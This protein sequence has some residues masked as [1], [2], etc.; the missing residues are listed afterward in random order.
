M[1]MY[2][3]FLDEGSSSSEKETGLNNIVCVSELNVRFIDGG[4]FIYGLL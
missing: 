3:P 4:Q 1:N 2:H